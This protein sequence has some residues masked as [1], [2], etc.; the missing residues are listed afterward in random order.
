MKIVYKTSC[1][2]T[3]GSFPA[4]SVRDL[5]EAKALYLI[6][7][8]RAE[9]YVEDNPIKETLKNEV[10]NLQPTSGRANKSKRGKRPSKN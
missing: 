10:S 2:G 6:S 8:G 9:M 4:G 1:S 5:P 7:I 3:A